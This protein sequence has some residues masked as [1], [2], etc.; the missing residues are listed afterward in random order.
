MWAGSMPATPMVTISFF[1]RTF[2]RWKGI[3]AAWDSLLSMSEKA[4]SARMNAI[5]DE[6]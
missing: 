6:R 3:S 2:M 1:S 5:I 4:G